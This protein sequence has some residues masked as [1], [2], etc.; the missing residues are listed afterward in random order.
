[1]GACP[2]ITLS[3]G[4]SS[5]PLTFQPKAHKHLCYICIP[6]SRESLV[7]PAGGEAQDPEAGGSCSLL[8]PQDLAQHVAHAHWTDQKTGSAGTLADSNLPH[9]GSSG[10]GPPALSSPRTLAPKLDLKASSSGAALIASLAQGLPQAVGNSQEIP[11]GHHL[12]NIS[13]Q[14]VADEI[15]IIIVS[16][17]Y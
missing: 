16:I 15:I 6:L 17:N 11:T 13:A 12:L 7:S 3:P 5:P 1:M 2:L 9:H 4:P 14:I 8:F 10:P